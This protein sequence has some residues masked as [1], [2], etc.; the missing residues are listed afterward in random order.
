MLSSW[1]AH[2]PCVLVSG[3]GEE[4]R[5]EGGGGDGDEEWL[6]GGGLEESRGSDEAAGLGLEVYDDEAH[7]LVGPIQQAL[8]A[9]ASYEES[10]SGMHTPCTLHL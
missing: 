4:R 2:V 5:G 8:V 9:E 10:R 1:F 7:M 6:G 3:V